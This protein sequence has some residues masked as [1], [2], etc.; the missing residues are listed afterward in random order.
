MS[1]SKPK[2]NLEQTKPTA[3]K[4]ICCGCGKQPKDTAKDRLP[5]GWKRLEAEIYC[6]DCWDNKFF[7]RAITFAVSGPVIKDDWKEFR[8][9]LQVGWAQSTQFA[10][11]LTTE[12]A[13][14]DITRGPTMDKLPP[15]DVPYLYNEGRKFFPGLASQTVVALMNTIQRKYNSTRYDRIWLGR[16]SLQSY[17][18]PMPL[19]VPAASY[20]CEMMKRG[21]DAVPVVHV[22]IG[23][24]RF[25]L[26]LKGGREWG[27]QL[28]DFQKIVAGEAVQCEMAIGRAP[29]TQSDGHNGLQER[30]A[31][32]GARQY[33][34]IM[35][36]VVAW[37]PRD[38]IKVKKKKKVALLLK[39]GKDCFW[40][41]E[42]DGC[43]PWII[44]AD[45]VRRWVVSHAHRLQTWSDDQKAE[46]RRTKK[47]RRPLNEHR[48][49][50]SRKQN[51]RLDT[52]CH[53]CA[54]LFVQWCQR[55]RVTTVNYN[56]TERFLESFPW[57]RLKS[58]L[59]EKLNV[60]GIEFVDASAKAQDDSSESTRDD[61]KA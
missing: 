54:A 7:L 42:L 53:T 61:K 58:L 21:S 9:S 57:H 24:R 28:N 46:K 6:G 40:M 27:R 22:R 32:G 1:K 38:E 55:Q 13:K 43:K 4:L 23:D 14:A 30:A 56:D 37:L 11:W 35:L 8:E 10:N 52:W 45:H 5:R 48:A 33:Y 59:Q 36:K 17:K 29:V 12:F 18:Y 60:A 50:A 19:P 39:T 26:Q 44:H 49:L 3:Q 20:S 25:D 41:A 2:E 16:V 51:D 31:G 47:D 34:R 15:F